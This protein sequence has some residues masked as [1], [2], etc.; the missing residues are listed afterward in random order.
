[1]TIQQAQTAKTELEAEILGLV[2]AFE[3]ETG[4][5]VTRIDVDAVRLLAN[6]GRRTRDTVCVKID[7]EL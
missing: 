1:M 7:A 2:Q 6:N 3:K 5:F 4:L